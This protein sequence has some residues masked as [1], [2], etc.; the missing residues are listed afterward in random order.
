MV[1]TPFNWRVSQCWWWIGLQIQEMLQMV[2]SLDWEDLLEKG[3]ETHSSILAWRISWTEESGRLQ[4]MGS[5]RVKHNWATKHAHTHN[6]K[7][8]NL[9]VQFSSVAQ[10]CLTLCDQI[11]R[12]MPG[13]PVHHQLPESTQTHVHRVGD[14]IQPS[15]PLSSPSPP[16]LNLSQNQVFSN[17]SAF[18]IR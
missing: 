12:S 10:S 16:V 13:L 14:A 5:Q 18:C 6:V 1:R 17:E 3:M 7:L 4:C 9:S 11:N 8:S 15:H 2:Q